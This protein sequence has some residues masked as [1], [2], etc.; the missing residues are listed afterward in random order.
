MSA[1]DA[2][3]AVKEDAEKLK[4]FCNEVHDVFGDDG[5][6][7]PNLIADKRRRS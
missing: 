2:R 5:R 3:Y 6:V 1:N 7:L 4:D